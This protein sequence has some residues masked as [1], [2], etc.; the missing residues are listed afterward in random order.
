M[1]TLIVVW[2]SVIVNNVLVMINIEQLC[3]TFIAGIAR[4]GSIQI[5]ATV[6]Y[7]RHNSCD[8]FPVASYLTSAG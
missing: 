6:G 2:Q 1:V 4:Q 7:I 5:L 8:T 3:L